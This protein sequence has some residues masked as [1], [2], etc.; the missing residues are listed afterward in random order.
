MQ[1]QVIGVPIYFEIN[2]T[3]NKIFVYNSRDDLIIYDCQL[4]NE[5]NFKYFHLS[6]YGPIENPNIYYFNDMNE[7]SIYEIKYGFS[8]FD[9]EIKYNINDFNK[10]DEY[11]TYYYNKINFW[12]YKGNI[13]DSK[14][15]TENFKFITCR[16]I[17]L[18]FQ[19]HYLT[20]AYK[21]QK[22][23]SSDNI[24]SV[25]C[26]DFVSACCC[27]SSN[28]F[29]IGLKNGK[30]ISYK[31]KIKKINIPDT[32]NKKR[33]NSNIQEEILNIRKDKYIQGH[34]GKINTIDVD[35]RLGVI[36]TSGD[37]N[38]V[39][40]RKLYDFEL[41]T[42]IKLKNKYKVLMTKT[43]SFNFLYILCFNII[44][45][46]RIIF[47]YTLSGIRFAKSDYSLY[48]NI[49]FTDDGDI[50]TLD[51][52][53]VIKFLSGSNLKILNK[54]KNEKNIEALGKIKQS[55]WVQ[56]NCFLRNDEENISRI[57]TYLYE[58]K[59]HYIK[60]LNLENF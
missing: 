49:S 38:Y 10:P 25:L 45:N 43:S 29:V 6:L 9:N 50:F 39:Y 11:H 37:D 2:P 26:E 19:I 60:T 22:K 41:L 54:L 4:F 58:D 16:H 7:N 35:K 1:T 28:S 14:N 42:P 44:N 33:K 36:I 13:D 18:T 57:I 53:K 55:N 8:S 3:I 47:G 32:S 52:K 46:K 17:D 34:S 40:I 59:D 5:T 24:F 30:L 23:I 51:N 27:T 20:I 15:N 56:L 12:L 21:D 48:D 31:L